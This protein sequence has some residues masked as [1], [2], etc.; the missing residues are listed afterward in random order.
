MM[1]VSMP[2]AI[3]QSRTLLLVLLTHSLPDWSEVQLVKH[4]KELQ[5][6]LGNFYLRSTSKKVMER[7]EAHEPKQ[8]LGA[9]CLRSFRLILTWYPS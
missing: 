3:A 7:V 8:G 4:T 2:Q 9:C 1:L 5:S 6:L